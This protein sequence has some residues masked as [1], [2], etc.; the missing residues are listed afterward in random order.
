[1]FILKA[2]NSSVG[3]TNLELMVIL[4]STRIKDMTK[5]KEGRKQE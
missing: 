2:G 3:W 5:I 1:L 4:S